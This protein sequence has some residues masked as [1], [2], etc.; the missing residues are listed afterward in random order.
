MM[1]ED[2]IEEA[3]HRPTDPETGLGEGE[4]DKKIDREVSKTSSDEKAR[5]EIEHNKSGA[6]VHQNEIA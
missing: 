6:E 4:K 1:D 5:P 2:G 3:T